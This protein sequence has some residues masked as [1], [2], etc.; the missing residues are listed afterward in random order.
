MLLIQCF[1]Q[2]FSF[3]WPPFRIE[4]VPIT[5]FFCSKSFLDIHCLSEESEEYLEPEL[6]EMVHKSQ[7]NLIIYANICSDDAP[8]ARL[9]TLTFTRK[10]HLTWEDS[11]TGYEEDDLINFSEHLMVSYCNIFLFFILP[12]SCLMS[13][14]IKHHLSTD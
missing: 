2:G 4:I 11:V 3:L 13:K 1:Y 12:A 8:T 6:R 10:L 14:D 5:F 7:S 9:Y